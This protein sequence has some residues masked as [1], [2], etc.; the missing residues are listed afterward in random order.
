ME[1][2]DS[3]FDQAL[4]DNDLILIDFWAEWCSPC[5]TVSPILDEIS[6]ETG[7]KIGKLNI[8]Q[9]NIKTAEYE[10]SSIPNMILFKSGQ[11]V[12]SIIGARPKHVILEEIK[13]W[14]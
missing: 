11:P 4:K 14:I 2:N 7:L 6:S 10:V 8:D 5:R 3:T 13:E 12:K 1:I 9:N